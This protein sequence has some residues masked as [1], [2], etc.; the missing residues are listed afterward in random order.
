MAHLQPWSIHVNLEIMPV[1]SSRFIPA[2]T[3]VNVIHAEVLK[4]CDAID[5]VRMPRSNTTVPN[6]LKLYCPSS[7][8]EFLTIPGSAGT[9][10]LDLALTISIDRNTYLEFQFPTG[11]PDLSSRS[12]HVDMS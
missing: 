11:N 12:K 3:W 9:T 5:G 4:Q 1:N 6:K 8:T 10:Q 7:R 2:E